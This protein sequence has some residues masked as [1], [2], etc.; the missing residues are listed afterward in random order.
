MDYIPAP[1]EY[2]PG[3]FGA[4][5]SSKLADLK[6]N[7]H[8]PRDFYSKGH[9]RRTSE[10]HDS[11]NASSGRATPS[12]RPKWY[13]KGSTTQSTGALATLLSQVSAT[14]AAPAVPGASGNLPRYQLPPSRSSNGMIATAVDMI[15]HPG[16]VS[17]LVRASLFSTTLT[18]RPALPPQV[19]TLA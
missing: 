5:L 13:E 14:T 9:S 12:K 16:N 7:G 4:I 2:R 3:I 10:I 8:A 15:K 18:K 19:G 1:D 6:R 11:S 17:T